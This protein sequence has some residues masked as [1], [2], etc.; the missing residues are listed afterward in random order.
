MGISNGSLKLKLGDMGL[1][2]LLSDPQAASDGD[3]RYCPAEL[4][5][6]FYSSSDELSSKFD[7][8]MADIF[9]LGASAYELCKGASLAGNSS[10]VD[11]NG[12]SEWQ[13]LR[14]GVLN[15]SVMSKYSPQLSDLIIKVI[16]IITLIISFF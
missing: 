9:C 8:R 15:S 10:L 2:C 16:L 4:M 12:V 11:E 5:N 3:A 6:G 7:L 13:A 1:C 14:S